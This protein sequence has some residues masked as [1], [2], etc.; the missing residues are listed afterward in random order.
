[1]I[2]YDMRGRGGSDRVADSTHI[3]I[4]W[5]V[6]DL[7]T[8][9]KHFGAESFTP[10]G[11][12]YLG[13]M[14]MMYAADHPDR[15]DRVVQIGPISRKYGT[16]YLRDLTA[17]A[18]PPIPDADGNSELARLRASQTATQNQLPYCRRE[19]EIFRASLVGDARLADKV[20]DV[21]EYENEWPA[22]FGR[23][24]RTLFVNSIVPLDMDWTS[25]AKVAMPVLT[26]HGTNDRNAPYGSGREWVSNLPNARL[27]TVPGA[28]HMVWIDQPALV[29]GAID[30]FLKGQW[31]RNAR[32]VE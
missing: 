29:L 30:Q 4:Q 13:L 14:V 22:N 8:V 21:C 11:W 12:S 25:F 32:P 24:M 15:V 3:T 27:L 7:E 19:H 6:S 31:P 17:D 26:I 1:M 2:F 16:K 28:G 10:I 20:P 5:D 23:H 9:R 18:L